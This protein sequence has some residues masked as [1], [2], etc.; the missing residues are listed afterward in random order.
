MII[1]QLEDGPCLPVPGSSQRPPNC[2]L[3]IRAAGLRLAQ[4]MRHLEALLPTEEKHE[5]LKCFISSSEP[6][7]IFLAEKDV[8]ECHVK[9]TASSLA[10]STK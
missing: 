6:G 9:T 4:R 5:M 7:T 3:F 1:T 10:S 2:L 8:Y